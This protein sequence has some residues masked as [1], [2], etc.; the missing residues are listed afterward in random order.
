MRLSQQHANLHC[1]SQSAFHLVENQVMDSS[2]K[3]I[4]IMY[5]FIK[6][7]LSKNALKLINIDGDFNPIAIFTKMIP[8]YKFSRHRAILEILQH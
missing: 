7:A 6:Q 8:S 1:D 2:I 3:Y 4:D 5:H